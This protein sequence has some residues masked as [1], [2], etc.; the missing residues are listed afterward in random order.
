MSDAEFCDFLVEELE[1]KIVEIGPENVACFFA[2]PIAGAGGVLVPPPGYHARTATICKKYDLLYISDEVVA[3]F[4]RLGEMFASKDVFGLQPD[5]IVSAKG[6]T[7]GYAPLSATLFSEE[8]YEVIGVPQAEG[9]I[10]THGFTYS[11]HPVCCAAALKNI[12][13]MQRID[14]C[15]HVRKVY[16]ALLALVGNSITDSGGARQQLFRL[17]VGNAFDA[18]HEMALWELATCIF[19]GSPT[20]HIAG[21]TDRPSIRFG[22]RRMPTQPVS[23]SYDSAKW[24]G[25]DKFL[26]IICG[27]N[28]NT[29][30]IKLFISAVPR[31]YNALSRFTTR[32]GSVASFALRP[33]LIGALRQVTGVNV[34][35][36]Q[37]RSVTNRGHVT[38]N[39][40]GHPFPG[41]GFKVLDVRQL[42]TLIFSMG[43]DGGRKGVFAAPLETGS[44]FKNR[45]FV[46]PV[47][48]QHRRHFGLA[49]S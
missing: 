35:I 31:P 28:A 9:A 49:D 26:L 29:I 30:A 1:Q 5:V 7:S 41:D 14:L 42:N 3:A 6:L 32:N 47:R 12:E 37:Q 38:I 27:T 15:G 4:G 8:I 21:R 16:I 11:G 45:S 17:F 48:T 39:G 20:I 22:S 13:I 36:T 24:I 23:S 10:F 46:P 19:V 33:M 25:V 18:H 40:T 43:N 34:V 2:E 44:K